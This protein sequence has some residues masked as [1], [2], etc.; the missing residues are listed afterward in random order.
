MM[1]V[2]SPKQKNRSGRIL[3]HGFNWFAAFAC[4]VILA[5]PARAQKINKLSLLNQSRATASNRIYKISVEDTIG[6]G[7]GLYTVRTDSSHPI[8]RRFN[9]PQDLLVGGPKLQVGTSY[10]TVRSYNTNVDYVQS[11]LARS[12]GD[13]TAFW[14]DP[15]FVKDDAVLPTADFFKPLA[16]GRGYRVIYALPGFSNARDEMDIIQKIE[17]HGTDFGDSW[18]EISTMVRNTGARQLRIGIRYMWDVAVGGDDGPELIENVFNTSLG[19]NEA[20]FDWLNFAFFMTRANDFIGLTSPGYNIFGSV[21]TPTNLLRAP[22]QPTRFQIVSWPRAFFKAFDYEVHPDLNITRD[23]PRDPT[24]IGGDVG[25][26]YFWGETRDRALTIEPGDSIQVTQGIFGG[27]PDDRPGLLDLE[28]PAC[29]LTAVNLGPPKS[30]E[31]A[32]Q[33]PVSGL[34]ILRPQNV[35]NANLEIPDFKTGSTEVLKIVGT[36][37]DE[38]QPFGFTL[39]ALDMC[40]N[41]VLCDPVFLTLRPGLHTNEQRFPLIPSDRY[42][43]IKNQGIRRIVANLNGHEFVLDA[44]RKGVYKAGNA[45]LMPLNGEMTIDLGRYLKP[46]GN[47]MSIAFAGPEDS[48]ADLIIS[49]MIMKSAVDLVLDLAPIP[50]NF[51]L[52]QN[53]PNPFQGVTTIHFDVP[54]ARD[55][56][57][58]VERVEL[59]IYN[60]LGQIVRTLVTANL[61]AGSYA[62][63]W[64]GRDETGRRV[65]AGVYIYSLNAGGVHITKKMALI[66]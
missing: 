40:G 61:P 59:K 29:E 44:E 20:S 51:S 17:I 1:K 45:F 5:L 46:D 64:N 24:V 66:Q 38:S 48:R 57:N 33:D 62:A 52:P 32:V 35:F 21:L 28:H 37:I 11:E 49:D 65:T 22:F 50:Q 31:F 18:V 56:L 63:R 36:V 2:P 26:Q 41:E 23:D 55:H 39:L 16:N 14:L 27:L 12:E 19:Q 54:E 7:V 9:K 42:F 25:V 34:R 4:L 53:L 8:S 13:F 6:K 30:F 47:T 43:Y 10:T 58:G 60:L 3:P 15:I